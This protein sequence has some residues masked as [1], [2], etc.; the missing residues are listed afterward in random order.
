MCHKSLIYAYIDTCKYIPC[1]PGSPFSPVDPG[2]PGAPAEP[3]SPLS[4]LEPLAPLRPCLP[5]SPGA[6]VSPG[7][8][9][10]PVAPILPEPVAPV[11]PTV[12]DNNSKQTLRDLLGVLYSH[13][14]G[15]DEV[16]KESKTGRLFLHFTHSSSGVMNH[17]YAN[18]MLVLIRNWRPDQIHCTVQC[19]NAK[20]V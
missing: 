10:I 15:G 14:V 4:P 9:C 6:P 19:L 7:T 16:S 13:G 3:V 8:P 5:C 18:K 1:I 20:Q 2:N 17:M 12:P 11:A